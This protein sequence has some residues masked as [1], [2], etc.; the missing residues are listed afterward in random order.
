MT[1]ITCLHLL[2]L[3]YLLLYLPYVHQYLILILSQSL[4]Q[5]YSLNMSL[6]QINQYFLHLHLLFLLLHLNL[7]HHSQLLKSPEPLGQRKRPTW[8]P[9][10]CPSEHHLDREILL[11]NG[12]RSRTLSSSGTPD[13][14][15][16]TQMMRGR[17]WHSSSSQCFQS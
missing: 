15:S 16:Q 7:V 8:I 3:L 17:P 13:Q 2:H 9:L 10:L 14:F 12:G 11:V 5:T 1:L 6:S 4:N